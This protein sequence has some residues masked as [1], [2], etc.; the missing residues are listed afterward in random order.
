MCLREIVKSSRM[1]CSKSVE[2]TAK[3][4]EKFSL[5]SSNVR[6]KMNFS[7]KG[8][9]HVARWTTCEKLDFYLP[10]FKREKRERKSFRNF[11]IS[12]MHKLR[13][14]GNSCWGAMWKVFN[15]IRRWLFGISDR[16][17]AQACMSSRASSNLESLESFRHFMAHG[18]ALCFWLQTLLLVM[19][20]LALKAPTDT[21]SIF[22]I[23][24]C[25]KAAKL[26]FLFEL[27]QSLED[28]NMKDLCRRCLARKDLFKI[29][30]IFVSRFLHA[31]RI[32]LN[33]KP[34][35]TAH[36]VWLNRTQSKIVTHCRLVIPKWVKSVIYRVW[37]TTARDTFWDSSKCVRALSTRYQLKCA[38]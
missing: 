30:L 24:F 1:Y 7:K 11:F 31:L 18:F 8:I 15:S 14:V 5:I 22:K 36:T 13:N 37:S 29:K 17:S 10:T 21:N 3:T 32:K 16:V 33:Q 4:T 20:F 12:F 35:S 6:V 27:G 34:S 28:C 2:A 38:R 26:L 19:S 9:N 25:G 23:E